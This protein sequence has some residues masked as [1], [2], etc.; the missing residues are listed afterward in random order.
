MDLNFDKNIDLNQISLTGVRAIVL[1]GLLSI[2]P[3]SLKEIR[4]KY[5]EYGIMDKSQ[6]D[7]MI[8][9]DLSTIKSFGC[10][11]SRSSAKTNF[12]YVLSKHPFKVNINEHDVKT[13]KHLFDKI[14]N[15][16][17][18]QKLLDYDAL[19]DKISKCISDEKVKEAFLGISPLKYYDTD[20]LKELYAACVNNYTVELMYKKAY[21]ANAEEKSIVAQ[22]LV[23]QNGKLYLYGYDLG[24]KDSVTLLFNRIKSIKSKKLTDKDYT[25][26]P[27][28]I[29]FILKNFNYEMLTQEEKIVKKETN[30]CTVE[31]SYF[32]EFLAIQR[33]LSFGAHCTVVEPVEFRNKII[34]KLKEMRKIYEKK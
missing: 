33:I 21:S 15:K 25:Q 2:K 26:K 13:I 11:I 6:S 4:H 27:V 17:S 9:I 10:K 1:I 18:I 30:T 8:R 19:S 34:S 31:G 22:K 29:R 12:Q 24:K 5:I 32:N 16:I 20:F 7:D 3:R 23:F 28:F 14:K